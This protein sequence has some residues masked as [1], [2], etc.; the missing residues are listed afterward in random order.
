MNRVLVSSTAVPM[1][2][3][4]T[5]GHGAPRSMSQAGVLLIE[6]MVGLTIFMITALGILQ[7]MARAG[8]DGMEARQ[9]T[10]AILMAQEYFSQLDVSLTSNDRTADAAR[11]LAVLRAKASEVFDTWKSTVLAAGTNELVAGSAEM[12]VLANDSN[13]PFAQVTISWQ[14]RSD[15]P[16]HKFITRRSFI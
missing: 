14:L 13:V 4:N 11:S 9:R 10:I 3:R 2:P 12:V 5:R 6:S 1:F 7:F 16:R 15:L 8:I